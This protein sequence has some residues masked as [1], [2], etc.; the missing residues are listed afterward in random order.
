MCQQDVGLAKGSAVIRRELEKELN[1][2]RD[3]HSRTLQGTDD[4]PVVDHMFLGRVGHDFNFDDVPLKVFFCET[5]CGDDEEESNGFDRLEEWLGE[6]AWSLCVA[7]S[8]ASAVGF[9]EEV[10][11]TIGQENII[12]IYDAP[13]SWPYVWY[14]DMCKWKLKERSFLK[15]T[16]RIAKAYMYWEM[17]RVVTHIKLYFFKDITIL[18]AALKRLAG[19][20]KVNRDGSTKIM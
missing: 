13:E 18:Q 12:K 11:L 10:R 16:T 3:T 2:L 5:S 20:Q 4:I 6:I 1:L 7:R 9:S 8:G 15:D 17:I 19:L 14:V